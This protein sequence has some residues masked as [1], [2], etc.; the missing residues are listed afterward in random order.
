MEQVVFRFDER[1]QQRASDIAGDQVAGSAAKP[2]GQPSAAIKAKKS[3]PSG[4]ALHERLKQNGYRCE[5]SGVVLEIATASV[6]H[7]MP[8]SRGG[9]HVMENLAV[10]HGA[11]NRMKGTMTEEEFVNWCCLVADHT[12]AKAAEM[13]CQK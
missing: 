1:T 8:L 12:R 9:E 13:A 4:K 11:V 6:D 2:H 5:L 10:I 7:R 3:R